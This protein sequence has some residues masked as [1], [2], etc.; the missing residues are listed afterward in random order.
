MNEGRRLPVW[1]IP[2][3]PDRHAYLQLPTR[4]LTEAEWAQF[5]RVLDTMRPGLT[6]GPESADD[7]PN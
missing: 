5:D 7:V 3:T 6:K 2:I 4:S 1:V